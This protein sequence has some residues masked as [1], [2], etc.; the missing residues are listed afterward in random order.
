MS[1][2]AGPASLPAPCACLI[3]L[4][5]W[6]LAPD[7][8]G[9]AVSLAEHTRLRRAVADL[10]AHHADGMGPR[11]GPARRADGQQRGRPPEPRRRLGRCART[12]C[13]STTPSPTARSPRTRCCAPRSS[14]RPAPRRPRACTC[15]GLVSDGGVHS[16]LEHLRA[17]I[18]MGVELGAGELV[19]HAFTDGRDTLPHAGRGV[20]DASSTRTPE[21]RVGSV[22][23]P[24]LGDGP[25]PPLGARA[26]RLRHARPRR[27]PYH[28]ASGEE[29]VRMAYERGETDEFIEPTLVGGRPA[30]RPGDSIIAFNFRP[31]RMREITR[32]LAEPGFG[33]GSEDLPGWEGRGGAGTFTRYATLTRYE[34]GWSYPVV[35]LPEHPATTLSIVLAKAGASPAA[36]RRDGEVPTRDVLLQRRRRGAAEAASDA[37]W[38][39]R[40]ATCRPTTSSPQMSAREAADAFVGR[41]ARGRAR[42]SGS[43][44]S[45]T[46]TWS[47]TPG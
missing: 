19:V 4:D 5:G 11:R 29:A 27:A 31:D 10:P 32:A 6:G 2:P 34:E 12:S 45:P 7:G 15:I 18:D 9:N 37:R 38:C 44:T 42:A 35:F 21:R 47:G 14:G 26:A 41:M 3:V 28:A 39:P 17:L 46:R 36:R 40:R 24:L 22:V 16:S 23:G 30:I 1:I 43:S 13:G 20:P 33:E 25:R 8:P